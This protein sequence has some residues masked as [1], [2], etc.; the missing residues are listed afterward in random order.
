[1]GERQLKRVQH[2]ARRLITSQLLQAQ[3]LAVAIGGVAHDR[4]AQELEVH[5]ELMGAAGVQQRFDQG[6]ASQPFHHAVT[7]PRGPAGVVVHSHPLSMRRMPGDGG[8]NFAFVPLHFAAQDRV[9][10]LVDF[11]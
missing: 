2:L 7:G 6:G 4:E 8:A 10:S 5:P 9:V 3:V 11:A 1:M